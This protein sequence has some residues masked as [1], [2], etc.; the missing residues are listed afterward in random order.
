ME[1][2]LS[3]ISELNMKELYKMAFIYNAIQDGW[4]IQKNPENNKIEMRKNKE[5]VCFESFLCK[6]M[7]KYMNLDRL[8]IDA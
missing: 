8:K 2:S 3:N 1:H 7:D 5:E 6:T 4:A